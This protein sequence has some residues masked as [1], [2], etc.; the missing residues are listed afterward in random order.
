MIQKVV[1]HFDFTTEDEVT[2]VERAIQEELPGNI[3][4]R[5]KVFEWLIDHLS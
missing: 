2:R 1:D 3:R 5:Q 4:G